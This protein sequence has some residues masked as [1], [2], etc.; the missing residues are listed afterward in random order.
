M[1][2]QP[3]QSAVRGDGSIAQ[4]LLNWERCHTL[5]LQLWDYRTQRNSGGED[6]DA[7]QQNKFSVMAVVVG[8][9]DG[10]LAS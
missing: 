9:Q 10:N 4:G 3:D 2:D 1:G 7:L 6:M 5:L 8:K